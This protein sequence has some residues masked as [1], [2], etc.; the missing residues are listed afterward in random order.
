M[1]SLCIL[2]WKEL[3]FNMRVAERDF[4]ALASRLYEETLLQQDTFARGNNFA[5]TVSN[6]LKTTNYK[7]SKYKC[8]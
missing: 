5:Q 2:N 6:L 8:T 1:T 3:I 7:S 4:F